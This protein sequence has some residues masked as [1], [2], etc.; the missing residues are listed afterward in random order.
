MGSLAGAWPTPTKYVKCSTSRRSLGGPKEEKVDR[1]LSRA[2]TTPSAPTQ[3]EEAITYATTT[4]TSDQLPTTWQ[5]LSPPPQKPSRNLSA[6]SATWVQTK[7]S[8]GP[9]SRNWIG[10]ITLPS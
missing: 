3:L 5:D 6:P 1:A 7:W 9:Q 2:S 8:V 4:A 10:S